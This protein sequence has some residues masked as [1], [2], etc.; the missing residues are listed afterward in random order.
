MATICKVK[1]HGLTEDSYIYHQTSS[2]IVEF[3][4]SNSENLTDETV[5]DAIETINTKTE[6]LKKER[7]TT[8]TF[9]ATIKAEEFVGTI[10]PYTQ[11]IPVDGVLSTDNPII[12]LVESDQYKSA[13]EEKESWGCINRITCDDGSITAY[14]YE[15][16]PRVDLT[17]Q[18][19]VI[20]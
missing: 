19:K 12:G 4:P 8:D 17:I 16:R 10:A 15:D 13:M 9:L 7:V 18:I 11:I 5:Q 2:D 20:R 3:D 1:E 14:C 6:T